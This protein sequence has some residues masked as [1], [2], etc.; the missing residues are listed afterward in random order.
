MDQPPGAGRPGGLSQQT[1]SPA[2]QPQ[3][4]LG[5]LWAS[6]QSPGVPDTHQPAEMPAAA[7]GAA[8][9]DPLPHFPP[10]GGEAKQL[11]QGQRAGPVEV[12]PR[13]VQRDV[14]SVD[15]A[16]S[17]GQGRVSFLKL[18]G[19]QSNQHFLYQSGFFFFYIAKAPPLWSV[20]REP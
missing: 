19:P 13:G 11:C 4:F 3:P 8:G 17:E 7:A 14:E 1:P 18:A 15:Q 16:P 10:R 2:A 20:H 9:M 6:G 12:P 5:T